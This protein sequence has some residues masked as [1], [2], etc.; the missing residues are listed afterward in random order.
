MESTL[1]GATRGRKRAYS[2]RNRLRRD[3][4][5]GHPVFELFLSGSST[6]SDKLFHCMI[7]Q[8]DV[9]ME[10]RGPAE[11]ARDFFGK[12]HWV[13]DVTYRVQNDMPS[14]VIG[15]AKEKVRGSASLKICC[16]H[17]LKLI[18]VSR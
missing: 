13:L 5:S 18:R 3:M 15:L 2:P 7:C 17:A 1:E 16:Q 10:S 11:F 12:G 14:I 9:S 4:V 6:A 8:R